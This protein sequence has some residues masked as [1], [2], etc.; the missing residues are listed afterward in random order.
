MG[1]VI[2]GIDPGS[3]LIGFS[4]IE[5]DM[6]Y[7]SLHIV[8]YGLIDTSEE[9]VLQKKFL[10]IKS[11]LQKIL[12]EYNPTELAIERLFFFKNSRTAIEVGESIGVI[13]LTCAERGLDIYTYTPLQVKKAITG[14]GMAKKPQVQ[15]AVRILLGLESIPKPDDVADA[16]AIAVCHINTMKFLNMLPK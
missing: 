12:E 4:I 14:F 15:E 9:K 2:L 16:I 8:R 3:T 10:R 6:E 11:E 5:T 7:K 1:K 13:V